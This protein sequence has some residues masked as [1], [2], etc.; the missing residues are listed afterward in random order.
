LS[1]RTKY[2]LSQIL[3]VRKANVSELERCLVTEVAAIDPVAARIARQEEI[4]AT[5]EQTLMTEQQQQFARMVNGSLL[6]HDAAQGAAHSAATR[7]ELKRIRH[8]LTEAKAEF[9]M[10]QRRV[11]LTEE[12]LVMARQRLA[13][14]ERHQVRHAQHVVR[15]QQARSEE[16][17]AE[18]WQASSDVSKSRS[19][20]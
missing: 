8:T 14:F 1:E 3:E 4:L 17:A 5:V 6:A 18:A 2:P 16:D 9:E 20:T 13:A 19:E 11:R 15:Q 7:G 12:K 10:L